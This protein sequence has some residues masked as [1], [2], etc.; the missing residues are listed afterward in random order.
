MLPL[1]RSATSAL[2]SGRKASPHGTSMPVATVSGADRSGVPPVDGAAEAG[3]VEAGAAEAGGV[4]RGSG[5]A[6]GSVSE[7]AARN[8][9]PAAVMARF[10][11]L[12]V[13]SAVDISPRCPALLGE[14]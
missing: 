10:Q 7:Q 11:R 13:R 3:A 5:A 6:V 1:L 2:P 12:L 9:M 4:S 14:S 8:A